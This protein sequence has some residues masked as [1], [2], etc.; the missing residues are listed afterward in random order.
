MNR[1][2][3]SSDSSVSPILRATKASRL[4]SRRVL[5]SLYLAT[6]MS[7][8]RIDWAR[9]MAMSLSYSV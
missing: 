6:A 9:V 5:T 2:P 8:D 7:F 3:V 4:L 1:I